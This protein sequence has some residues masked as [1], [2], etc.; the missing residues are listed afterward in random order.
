MA[1]ESSC[2]RYRRGVTH[3]LIGT[4][5]MYTPKAFEQNDPATQYQLINDYPFGTLVSH[6]EGKLAATHLP[7]LVDKNNNGTS[8]LQ[9]H[10]AKNNNEFALLP[11]GSSVLAIF[12]GPNAYISPSWYPSKASTNGK[13]VPTW[14]Y[15]SVHVHGVLTIKTDRIWL[16]EH[17]NSQTNRYEQN[18]RTPWSVDDAPMDYIDLMLS[19]IVGLEIVVTRIE[20]KEKL[21][22]NRP[23][24]DRQ[25]VIDLLPSSYSSPLQTA[26]N[27]EIARLMGVKQGA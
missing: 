20:A 22:Q 3:F 18:Q 25:G 24:A 8:V 21:S 12:H 1:G 10:I 5:I 6:A 14:N 26:M 4:C 19:A 9:A 13:A 15:A 23:I 17:L 11:D 27:I 7:F 2:L 16:L